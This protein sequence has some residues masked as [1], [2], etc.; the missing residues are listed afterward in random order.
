LPADPQA[1]VLATA[2]AKS[3]H[4]L[5]HQAIHRL[6]RAEDGASVEKAK[7]DIAQA[8]AHAANALAIL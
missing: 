4:T 3:S 8:I 5:I 1:I 6:L 2:A 7:V